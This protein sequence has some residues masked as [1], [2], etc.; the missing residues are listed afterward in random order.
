MTDAGGSVLAALVAPHRPQDFLTHHWPDKAFVSHGPLDRL[1]A[2]L[3]APELTNV[4]ALAARYRGWIR[5]TNGRKYQQMVAID[6]VHGGSLYRMG[7]T[8]Q[9][10]NIA[11]YVQQAPAELARLEAELG[12]NPGA[13]QASVFCSPLAEGLSVHFDSQ[14]LFSVQLAGVKRFHYAPVDE[15]PCPSGTQFV[16]RTEAFDDLYPQAGEGFPE[17]ARVGFATVEMAPGSVL[18]IPRGTWHHTESQGESVSVSIALGAPS[19]AE[20][21]L[22]QL[23]MLMLQDPA[24]RRPLYGGWG[25]G[26]MREDAKSQAA[27]LLAALP[28]L[29]R[30]LGVEDLMASLVPRAQRLTDLTPTSRFQKTPHSRIVLSPPSAPKAY[31]YEVLS[32]YLCDPVY[33]ERMTMRLEVAPDVAA[34]F[35]WLAESRKPFA[36]RELAS[37]FPALPFAEHRRILQTAVTAG[38]LKLLW[39]PALLGA[40]VASGAKGASRGSGALP[41]NAQP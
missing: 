25:G 32:L 22:E 17:P 38:L 20:C 33:G 30:A 28:G 34:V 7:L 31:S 12:I 5:F 10:E 15:I 41:V 18:F 35:R 1:P 39:F 19:A 6:Q 37:N 8:V 26:A 36:V 24:W 29:T 14:D 11:P 2:F 21:V 4:D 3:R 9:F 13:A 16:P 27:R 40:T 23:R